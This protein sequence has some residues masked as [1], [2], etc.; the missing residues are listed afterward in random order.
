MRD[1]QVHHDRGVHAEEFLVE[2]EDD[3]AHGH[4]PVG[5]AQPHAEQRDLRALRRD[6]DVTF[7]DPSTTC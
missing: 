1:R 2:V 5:L 4:L 6:E 3:F 7:D